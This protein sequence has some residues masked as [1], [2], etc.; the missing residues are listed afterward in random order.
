VTG[1]QPYPVCSRRRRDGQLGDDGAG[2]GLGAKG[3]VS[4]NAYLARVQP[5]PACRATSPS[6]SNEAACGQP[7]GPCP[8]LPVDQRTLLAEDCGALSRDLVDR[9]A[10]RCANCGCVAVSA[11]DLRAGLI[12]LRAT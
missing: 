7:G 2:D 1:S 10:T 8:R 6:S 11:S 3:A 4:I 5:E 9:E 12:A